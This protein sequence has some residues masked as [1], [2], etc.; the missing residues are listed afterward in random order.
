M[1]LDLPGQFWETAKKLGQKDKDAGPPLLRVF[2]AAKV[3]RSGDKN[4]FILEMGGS[5][6]DR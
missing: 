3:D 6:A 5:K 4:G 2:M 1:G